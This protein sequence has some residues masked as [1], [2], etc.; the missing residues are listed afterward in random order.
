MEVTWLPFFLSDS[1]MVH[2]LG[3]FWLQGSRLC[4]CIWRRQ[5]YPS[6]MERPEGV[7]GK[8]GLVSGLCCSG[9]A[10]L[11]KAGQVSGSLKFDPVRWEPSPLSL[12]KHAWDPATIWHLIPGSSLSFYSWG[13]DS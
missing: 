13:L 10:R 5:G 8:S 9:F 4:P 1:N 6:N 7:K 3:L 11:G 12:G 2:A